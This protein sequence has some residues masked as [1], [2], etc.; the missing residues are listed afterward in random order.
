M[1][2]EIDLGD[3]R[4]GLGTARIARRGLLEQPERRRIALGGEL[5][6]LLTTAQEQVVAIDVVRARVRQRSRFALRQLDRERAHDLVRHV[7]LDGEDVLEVAVVALGPQVTAAR[8]VDQLRRHAH[9]LS[10]LAYAA[11]D[12]VADAE[13]AA[14]L[15][16][17]KEAKAIDDLTVEVTMAVPDP[18][19]PR[20]LHIMRPH[21]PQAWKDMGAEQF[22]RRPVGTGTYRITAWERDRV[23][24]VA[25]ETAWRPAKVKNLDIRVIPENAGRV[26]ALNSGQV[27]LAWSLE[28]DAIPTLE[29]AGNKVVLSRTND[30][31]N[32]IL[33]H[34]KQGSP[35]AD[36]R[37][38]Q[39]LNYAYNKDAFIQTVLRSTARPIG[40]PAAS[41]MSGHFEDIKPYPYDP[42]RAK[43]LLTEAGYPNGFKMTAEI[44]TSTGEFQPTMENMAN[45]FKQV[46]V[47][48][49]IRNLSIAEFVQKV[50]RQKQW[51]GEAFSM[52]Y[53]GHPSAD[54]SRIMGTH[55]CLT[56]QLANREPH[57]CFEEIMPTILA[58]S[59]E[60]DEKK[61][62]TLAKQVAQFYHDQA[63]IVFSHERVLVDGV[64]PKLRGY[65]LVNR[66]PSYHEISFAN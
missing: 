38:R 6:E 27:D 44:V 55:S 21:E 40:Q 57:T 9:T 15:R 58:M 61:R 64:M 29:L 20:R 49:E 53:E 22:G 33:L 36:V 52:M 34:Q 42:A 2:G 43:R 65:K 28:A 56:R 46:G 39:A 32:L 31:L 1:F 16:G 7:V 35:L 41:T 47:A 50:L 30:T 8:R 24:G 48:M 18:I 59:R 5:V 37:V 19:L 17:I 51:E 60:F 13:G 45:D 4:F 10:R 26:Q 12:D 14:Q 63:A 25:A 11:F 54:I 62:D 23:V 66:V 3:T